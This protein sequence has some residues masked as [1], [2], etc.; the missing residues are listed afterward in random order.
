MKTLPAAATFVDLS[1]L[2][3]IYGTQKKLKDEISREH[4]QEIATIGA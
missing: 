3:T 2:T 4:S 1:L